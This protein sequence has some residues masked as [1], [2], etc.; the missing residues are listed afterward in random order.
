MT[1][2]VRLI[3]SLP[4]RV[5]KLEVGRYGKNYVRNLRP[6]FQA[7]HGGLAGKDP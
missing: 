1:P 4:L 2:S 7:K 6:N 3:L 5:V